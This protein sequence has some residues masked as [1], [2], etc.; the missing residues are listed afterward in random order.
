[1]LRT[2]VLAAA[3]A[4]CALLPAG[5]SAATLTLDGSHTIHYTADPGEENRLSRWVLDVGYG[6]VTDDAVPG[7]TGCDT[8][9][10]MPGWR[11]C[12]IGRRPQVQLDDGDD[13]ANLADG[14][15]DWSMHIG[16]ANVDAGTG[17]DDVTTGVSD[18]VLKGGPGDDVLH[19][20]QGTNRVEGGE[21]NDTLESFYGDDTKIGGPGADTFLG[22]YANETIDAVDGASTDTITCHGG[23]DTVRADEGD[24][25]GAGCEQVVRVAKP[26]T[27]PSRPGTDPSGGGGQTPI[28]SSGEGTDPSGVGTD[29]A[30]VGTDP[31]PVRPAV[32]PPPAADRTAPK[33]TVKVRRK[34]GRRVLTIR[35][36]EAAT[37]RI[38][39]KTKAL[40]ANRPLRIV[41]KGR[42]KAIRLVA[43]DAAG[44]TTV[45]KVR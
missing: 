16:A 39:R 7:L 31:A 29:P 8:L 18:D 36:D 13:I 41:V 24:T 9:N 42:R 27:D 14:G 5:A 20:T 38:G 37:L 22:H 25:I 26:G 45:K 12:V 3:L 17:D 19:P 2:T 35:A 32:G 4:V 44:N 15:T 33:L 6:V 40:A 11:H 28:P 21:G 1:M 23:T 34:R 43:R 30:E 10:L